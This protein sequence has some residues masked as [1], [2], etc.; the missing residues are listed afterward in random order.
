[1]IGFGARRC[2]E[3]GFSGKDFA[4]F[5]AV[6]ICRWAKRGGGYSRLYLGGILFGQ[7]FTI[8]S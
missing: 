1:M 4:T 5:S 8:Y 2:D 6:M 3:S 7:R